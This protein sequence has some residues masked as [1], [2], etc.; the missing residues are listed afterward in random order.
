MRQLIWDLPTR[1]F[2]W[3]LVASVGF[4]ALSGFLLPD[5][6]FGWHFL[7]GYGIGL[8]LLFRVVWGFLGPEHSRWSSFPP[9]PSA[10]IAHI[11]ALLS[12]KPH[13]SLGHNPAGGAMIYALLATL[14]GLV[15]TGLIVLGGEEKQGPLAGLIPYVT[16]MTV[17]QLHEVLANVILLLAGL[18]I[19]G[20]LVESRLLRENLILT[21]IDGHK[22]AAP[23]TPPP[24]PR[25]R[26]ALVVLGGMAVILAFGIAEL[27]R[28]PVL[29]WRP[30]AFPAAYA[31][32][33]GACHNA[34]HPSLLPAA[35]W[36]TV[37]GHLSEHFGEDASLP[38][39]A[40]NDLTAWLTANAAETWDTEA[41]NRLRVVSATEPGRITA[42]PWWIRKHRHI[43]DTVFKQ[44]SV[45]SRANCS[46]CHQDAERGTFAVQAIAIPKP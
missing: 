6:W 25:S 23:G 42:A 28:L 3:L 34:Y 17:K 41:A 10:I 1:L 46:A 2:H 45:K 38:A 40:T 20:V 21:M 15:I 16:G 44:N 4:C 31:K 11:K 12:A 29:G 27:E 24:R 39:A 26:K 7:S 14:T 43:A 32:E 13:R 18:H 22:D 33:C 19:G 5:N 8:L 35:S 37:M 9:S 30:I 36:R